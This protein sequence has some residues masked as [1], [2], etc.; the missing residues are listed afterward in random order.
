MLT[1]NSKRGNRCNGVMNDLRDIETQL[2]KLTKELKGCD[3]QNKGKLGRLT[4]RVKNVAA[5]KG[6]D[7]DNQ[8]KAINSLVGNLHNSSD[9]AFRSQPN[10][11]ENTE[12][13]K[14]LIH[15]FGYR[16]LLVR[17]ALETSRISDQL[18]KCCFKSRQELDMH[19]ELDLFGL[20][21]KADDGFLPQAKRY[22]QIKPDHISKSANVRTRFEA[23]ALSALDL[24]LRY[25][26]IC[27]ERN[28]S[29]SWVRIR[30]ASAKSEVEDKNGRPFHFAQRDLVP[31]NHGRCGLRLENNGNLLVVRQ[32]IKTSEAISLS[33]SPYE[34]LSAIHHQSTCRRNIRR[35]A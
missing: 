33:L 30:A 12:I 13:K 27:K 2:A 20:D 3:T 10:R 29:A 23:L 26:I 19:L 21:T 34:K 6:H 8:I 11:P 5:L 24:A 28:A 7:L 9:D 31:G 16:E 14:D 22:H 35:C 4:T 15:Q 17:L 1:L 32:E 18:H 25:T